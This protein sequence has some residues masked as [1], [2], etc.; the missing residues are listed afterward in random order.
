MFAFGFPVA[1]FRGNSLTGASI[2]MWFK[3]SRK[4]APSRKIRENFTDREMA[5]VLTSNF[6]SPVLRGYRVTFL[7]RRHPPL[8]P[9]SRPIPMALRWSWWGGVVP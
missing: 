3:F 1:P 9:Y 2:Q 6:E 7:M 4:S 8:G 5:R